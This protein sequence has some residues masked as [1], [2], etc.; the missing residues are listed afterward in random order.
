MGLDDILPN[1][2]KH[3]SHDVAAVRGD[4]LSQARQNVS[5]NEL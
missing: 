2:A 4:K 5:G 3:N 1:L